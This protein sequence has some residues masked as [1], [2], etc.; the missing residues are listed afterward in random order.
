MNPSTQQPEPVRSPRYVATVTRIM[1][2]ERASW[3]RPITEAE[4]E[5]KREWMRRKFGVKAA[6]LMGW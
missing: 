5:A 2:Q 4:W 3:S 6:R 1:R